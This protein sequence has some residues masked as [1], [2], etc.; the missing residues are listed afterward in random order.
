M[1]TI[2]IVV[3][4]VLALVVGS[5]YIDIKAILE[6]LTK[7]K[8]VKTKNP[9]IWPDDPKPE[10]HEHDTTIVGIVHGW[11]C[12]RTQCDTAELPE[13]VKVLDDVFPMLIKVDENALRN[14]E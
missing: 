11:N 14:G 2:T 7:K 3:L 4:V 6:S 13:V 12:F 1:D 5:D 8:K 9:V 10:V